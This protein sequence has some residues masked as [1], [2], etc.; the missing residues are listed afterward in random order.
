MSAIDKLLSFNACCVNR[1]F[2][3]DWTI[4]TGVSDV[5]LKN[6]QTLIIFKCFYPINQK[7]LFICFQKTVKSILKQPLDLAALDE[8]DY[9]L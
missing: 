2:V 1:C 4:Q 6:E 3:V 9:H 7:E 5:G 8:N